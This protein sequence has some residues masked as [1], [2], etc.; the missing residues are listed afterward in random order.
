MK[1]AEKNNDVINSFESY[2][3][4]LR[5]GLREGKFKIE[6]VEKLI[7][8]HLKEMRESLISTT[9]EIINEV[10]KD[11]NDTCKQCGRPLK[12]NKKRMSQ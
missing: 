12:K 5:E 4:K 3:K 7:G 1:S 11:D 2:K 8:T 9:G 10:T 6:D